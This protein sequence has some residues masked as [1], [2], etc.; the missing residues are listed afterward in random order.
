MAKR[1]NAMHVST[2]RRY[3]QL[4][5]GTKRMHEATLLRRSYREGNKVKNETLSN[6]SPLPATTIDLIPSP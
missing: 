5:D 6:L 4:K 2:T 1:G 3:Y